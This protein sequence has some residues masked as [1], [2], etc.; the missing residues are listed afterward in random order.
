ML[1]GD[2]IDFERME[3][4]ADSL[5]HHFNKRDKRCILAIPLSSLGGSDEFM[6]AYSRD[7][8]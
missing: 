3:W 6:W 1:V 8:C 2:L 7:G 4:R 5:D